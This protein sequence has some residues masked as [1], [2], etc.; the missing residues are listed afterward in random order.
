MS[1][2]G[3][4]LFAREAFEVILHGNALA[5]GFVHLQRESAAQQRLAHQQQ[6]QI[7]ARIHVKVQQQR[8]LF[9]R[10]MAQQL[11]FVADENRVLLLALI[12]A[13][14]GLGDLAHQIAAVVG[15]LQIQFL[16][17][18]AEQ[19]QRRSRGPV[20]IEDLIYKLGLSAALKLRAAVDMPEPTSPVS[21]PAP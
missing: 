8:K 21:S 9:E 18:L 17:Q 20:Q 4:E 3:V 10:G 19:I 15:R 14:D 12:E 2:V 16:R 13:H 1:K 5:Q 7:A 6:G 11:G